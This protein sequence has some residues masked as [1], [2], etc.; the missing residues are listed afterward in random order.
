MLWWWLQ[1]SS[2][3]VSIISLICFK[4]KVFLPL[5]FKDT[6][7]PWMTTDEELHFASTSEAI[8]MNFCVCVWNAQMI[9]CSEERRLRCAEAQEWL[10]AGRHEQGRNALS[11]VETI[12]GLEH[13]DKEEDNEETNQQSLFI[14][15]PIVMFLTTSTKRH[16]SGVCPTCICT[17]L[18]AESK[19]WSKCLKLDVHKLYAIKLMMTSL[20]VHY[21]TLLIMN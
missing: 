7:L 20:T 11:D 2:W 19:P 16:W 6:S 8:V 12:C 3:N 4:W 21:F 10:T 15:T 17:L 18:T 14:V 9:N 13:E 1:Y 5:V